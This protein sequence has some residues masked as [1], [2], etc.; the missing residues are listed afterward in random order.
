MDTIGQPL[1]N[2]MI[3]KPTDN[4]L[5]IAFISF[6]PLILFI[7]LFGFYS[8][9]EGMPKK[10][11]KEKIC[12]YNSLLGMHCFQLCSEIAKNGLMAK[13]FFAR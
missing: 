7:E 5:T 11:N 1:T 10:W 9:A 8:C 12:N 13:S 4:L 6:L 3:I 2:E